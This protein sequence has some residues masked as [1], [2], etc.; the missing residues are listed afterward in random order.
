V[1][2]EA[3]QQNDVFAS[4][5]TFAG[6]EGIL[7][8]PEA[9]HAIH[10]AIRTAKNADEAGKATTIL[11]NLSGHGHFDMSAYDKYLAGTLEDIALD[12]DGIARALQAIEGLPV[13]G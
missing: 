9:A 7:P 12:E 5:L 3:Y 11:F 4:A 2:A 1:R 10:G 6:S 8:A 13:P